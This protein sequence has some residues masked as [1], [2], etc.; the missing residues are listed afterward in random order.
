MPTNAAQTLWRGPIHHWAGQRMQPAQEKRIEFLNGIIP[1]RPGDEVQTTGRCKRETIKDRDWAGAGK[2]AP[3]SQ[4]D[5][6][7]GIASTI[8]SVLPAQSASQSWGRD[9]IN[10]EAFPA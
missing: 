2:T 8:Q 9:D 3:I 4:L 7:G 5:L 6:N 10:F 1:V